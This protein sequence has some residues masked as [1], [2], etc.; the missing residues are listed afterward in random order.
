[1]TESGT[2]EWEP[3]KHCLECSYVLDG[4]SEER[5]PEC[6]RPFD[7]DDPDTFRQPKPKLALHLTP[8]LLG[9]M[10]VG[11]YIAWA[12][13]LESL[14]SRAKDRFWMTL[15]LVLIVAGVVL[16]AIVIIWAW[17]KAKGPRRTLIILWSSLAAGFLLVLVLGV[18]L[19]SYLRALE[20]IAGVRA[21]SLQCFGGT[22]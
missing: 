15:D 18:H 19:T 14:G 4:L 10:G 17:W 1:M 21:R 20:D 5:C 7:P 2:S 3:T 9:W 16:A 8:L 11:F 22:P 6:G 13:V 12:F